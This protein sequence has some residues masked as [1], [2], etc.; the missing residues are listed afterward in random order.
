MKRL[1]SS[2]I[3]LSQSNAWHS[4]KSLFLTLSLLS[5]TACQSDLTEEK[6]SRTLTVSGQGNVKIPTTIAKV[7]L[8]V[9]AQDKTAQQVQQQVAQKSSAVVKLLKARKVQ[10][11]ETTGVNLN[12]NYSY[13]DDKQILIGYSGTNT[14]SFRIETQKAGTILDD[15]VKVGANRI[16][17]V[18]FVASDEA[19]A[20]ARQQAIRQATDDAKLQADAALSALNLSQRAVLSVQ[21][22][23]AYSPEPL[24]RYM[25]GTQSDLVARADRII[26]PLIGGEQQIA[27]VVTLRI[28]Y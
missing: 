4:L 21:I 11:L 27:A 10:K 23:R 20:K 16:N 17:G 3:V 2:N 19:I 1:Q 9:N 7:S 8:G 18:S 14:V 28:R 13:K 15:T 22:E 12:A 6:I 24:V 26:T 25:P 5:F